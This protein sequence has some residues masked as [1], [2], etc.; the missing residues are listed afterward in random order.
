VLRPKIILI[1]VNEPILS[2]NYDFWFMK[3]KIVK[4]M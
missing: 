4:Y 1:E 3:R 2:L